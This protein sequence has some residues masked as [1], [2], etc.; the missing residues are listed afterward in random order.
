MSLIKKT[1]I[2]ILWVT[3]KIYKMMNLDSVLIAMYMLNL[4]FVRFVCFVLF[5]SVHLF[6]M[7]PYLEE[8]GLTTYRAALVQNQQLAV[9]AKVCTVSSFLLFLKCLWCIHTSIFDN[10]WPSIVTEATPGELHA[11]CPRPWP[12][13]WIGPEARHGQLFWGIARYWHSS[14]ARADM[15][16]KFQT[17]HIKYYIY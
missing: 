10:L 7:F 11:L 8:G 3:M 16:N 14:V 5:H 12:L 17:G 1:S 4:L 15:C 9:L 13:S 6:Y 2:H